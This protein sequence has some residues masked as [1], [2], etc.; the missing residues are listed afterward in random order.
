MMTSLKI[1]PFL[2]GLAAVA[3]M[4]MAPLA[5]TTES[6]TAPTQ[7]GATPVVF[8]ATFPVASFSV[9]TNDVLITA[10]FA[11]T[12]T[13]G[14]TSR[15]SFG[16]GATSRQFEPTHRYPAFGVY[17]VTLTVTNAAGSDTLAVFIEFIDPTATTTT[18]GTKT[19]T[20]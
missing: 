16:D 19:G 20:C 11:N 10:I 8:P 1:R 18:T 9:T 3:L 6:P 13:G 5:C 7:E 15:W 14:G 17:L 2:F 4:L 12:S